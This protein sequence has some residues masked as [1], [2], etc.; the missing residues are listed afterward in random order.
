MPPRTPASRAV[1][2]VPDG[3]YFEVGP[4]GAADGHQAGFFSLRGLSQYALL[5]FGHTLGR[6]SL[7]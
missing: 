5:H 6:E 7:L 4:A 3:R 2:P 1:S